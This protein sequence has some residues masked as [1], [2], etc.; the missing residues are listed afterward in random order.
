MQLVRCIY[1]AKE[2]GKDYRKILETLEKDPQVKIKGFFDRYAVLRTWNYEKPE[3]CTFEHV[4]CKENA[5]K[6]LGE[7]EYLVLNRQFVPEDFA[8]YTLKRV[9]A[10]SAYS[11]AALLS[12][13]QEPQVN[14]LANRTRRIGYTGL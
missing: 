6:I 7:I 14:T 2:W 12:E 1:L 10:K 13:L 9:D 8:E 5:D 4:R 11:L 3:Q